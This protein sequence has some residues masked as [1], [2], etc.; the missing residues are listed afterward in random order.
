M[1]LDQGGHPRSPYASCDVI[2]RSW[3]KKRHLAFATLHAMHCRCGVLYKGDAVSFRLGTKDRT[4]DSVVK[5]PG[6]APF[7]HGSA[8]LVSEG[9]WT[10]KQVSFSGLKPIGRNRH[11]V[12]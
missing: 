2:K 12:G 5:G 11:F 4:D 7:E 1:A 9:A 10:H 8:S 3:Y 6:I